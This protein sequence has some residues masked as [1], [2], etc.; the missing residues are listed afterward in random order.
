VEIKSNM[1]FSDLLTY[2]VFPNSFIRNGSLTIQERMLFE[3]LCSYD[4]LDDDGSRKG[5]CCP[6]LDRLSKDLGLGVRAIQVHLKRLV[7]KSMITVVYRNNV[8][9]AV[10]GKSSIY[11][12]NI[13]PGLSEN[14]RKRI[15]TIRDI[16][17]KNLISGLNVIRV[18]T[19]E[20]F[21]NLATNE[22][23]LHYLLT[24]E[25]TDTAFRVEGEVIDEKSA[26]RIISDEQEQKVSN[27]DLYGEGVC[28]YNESTTE[29]SEGDSTITFRP[30]SSSV[31]K[32]ATDCDSRTD[33]LSMI[34]AGKFV[35]IKEEHICQYFAELYQTSYEGEQYFSN[36]KETMKDQ[37]IL[38]KIL[39]TMEMEQL[40][41]MIEFYVTH[42]KKLFHHTNHPRPR[43]RYLAV[44]WIF[45]NLIKAYQQYA[46][47]QSEASSLNNKQSTEGK[48][49]QF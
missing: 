23:D 8:P 36:V 19:A 7:K 42:Y 49:I 44:E 40:V 32:G 24:G 21:H 22:F 3:I 16:E 39:E 5:W 2:C 34:R 25:K 45:T 48:T 12:L 28:R 27:K 29:S 6:S 1:T 17:I 18:Q 14:D 46:T 9:S 41:P 38:T 43:I 30:S 26:S 20:G 37:K 33:P 11:I 15:A 13:L 4:H 47:I 10:E 35:D 31:R